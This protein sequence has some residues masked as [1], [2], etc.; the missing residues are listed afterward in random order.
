MYCNNS[1]TAT[2]GSGC[3][4]CSIGEAGKMTLSGGA[5]SSSY[6]TAANEIRARNSRHCSSMPTC[7]ANARADIMMQEIGTS[8]L[9]LPTVIAKEQP[10]SSLHVSRQSTVQS[11][12]GR[13]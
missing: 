5:I 11:H 12:L 1:D 13:Q 8:L 6:T 2:T 4:S 7:S 10:L 9:A 3:I